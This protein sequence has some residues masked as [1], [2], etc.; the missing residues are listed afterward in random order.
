[1]CTAA[2]QASLRSQ[3]LSFRNMYCN[4]RLSPKKSAKGTRAAAVGLAAGPRSKRGISAPA[5]AGEDLGDI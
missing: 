4:H 1:M 2:C 5:A 3:G